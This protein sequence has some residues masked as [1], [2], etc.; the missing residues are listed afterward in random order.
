MD[1]SYGNIVPQSWALQSVDLPANLWDEWP[2]FDVELRAVS[3]G[4]FKEHHD[5]A[6]WMIIV[7]ES[8][9]I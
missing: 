9:S 1:P 8:C 3:D 2:Q 6:A 5:T 4:S 7:S